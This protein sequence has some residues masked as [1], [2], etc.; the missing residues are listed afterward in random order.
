MGEKDLT[1][2]FFRAFGGRGKDPLVNAQKEYI[3]F[4]GKQ[5]QEV[6]LVA[7]MHGYKCPQEVIDEGVRLRKEIEKYE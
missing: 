3:K 5:I 6:T 4:L 1:N 7:N 2:M